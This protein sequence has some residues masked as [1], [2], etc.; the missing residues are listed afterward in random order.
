MTTQTP[1]VTLKEQDLRSVVRN[2][3]HT[4]RELSNIVGQLESQLLQDIARLK[5][6]HTSLAALQSID[7]LAQSVTEIAAMLD[8]LEPVLPSTLMIDANE[9]VMPIRLENLR[10]LIGGDDPLPRTL[11]QDRDVRGIA[12][13]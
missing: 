4:L 1:N 2:T 6:T 12:M 8:R 9:V 5:A 3:G 13:F 10:N 7:L 11:S